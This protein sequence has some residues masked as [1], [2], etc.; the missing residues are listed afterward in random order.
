MSE[1]QA[2][3]VRNAIGWRI[4]SVGYGEKVVKR[5][6]KTVSAIASI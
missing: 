3:M 4:A 5:F 1:T 6:Q 2:L